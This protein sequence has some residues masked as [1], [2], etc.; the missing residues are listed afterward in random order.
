MLACV[1]VR[2]VI[3]FSAQERVSLELPVLDPKTKPV[4]ETLQ[5]ISTV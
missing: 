4:K 2:T 5:L 1:R 3:F